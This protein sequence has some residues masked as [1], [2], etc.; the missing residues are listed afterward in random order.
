[1]A[2]L[3]SFPRMLTRKDAAAYITATFGIPCSQKTLAKIAC[4]GADIHGVPGPLFRKAGPFTLYDPA[5]LDAWARS[6]IGPKVRTASEA[7]EAA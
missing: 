4:F 5:D 1:M 3:G 2:D 7:R 6:K